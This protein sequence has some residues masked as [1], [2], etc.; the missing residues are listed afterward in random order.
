[1]SGNIFAH[2]DELNGNTSASSSSSSSL[3]GSIALPS[4][5]QA[6]IPLADK[7]V[8]ES[9][10]VPCT[11]E[12][13]FGLEPKHDVSL[14]NYLTCATKDGQFFDVNLLH[15][16]SSLYESLTPEEELIIHVNKLEAM[17]HNFQLVGHM[18]DLSY[19]R[20]RKEDK[21]IVL[22]SRNFSPSKTSNTS[23]IFKLLVVRVLGEG[24]GDVIKQSEAKLYDDFFGDLSNVVRR[25]FFQHSLRLKFSLILT[26]SC[27]NRG[28]E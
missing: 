10:G 12:R 1:M 7:S 28:P 3:R 25:K 8:F 4:S 13:L 2:R 19:T 11:I 6:E 16:L 15:G 24:S 23:G 14:K 17:Q 20:R 26:T 5:S 27:S 18:N 9:T 22:S 21:S